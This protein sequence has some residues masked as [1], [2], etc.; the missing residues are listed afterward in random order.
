MNFKVN[1]LPY[2][3]QHKTLDLVSQ[4]DLHSLLIANKNYE[5]SPNPSKSDQENLYK[6]RGKLT[7]NLNSEQKLVVSSILKMSGTL[8]YLL[9]GP[10]GDILCNFYRSK[11]IFLSLLLFLH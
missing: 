5:R 8:P 11:F 4:Y 6:F 2:Q 3:I 9:F 10:A 1:K 7:A